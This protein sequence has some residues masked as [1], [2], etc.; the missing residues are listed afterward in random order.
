MKRKSAVVIMFTMLL[1]VVV[2]GAIVSNN[3][4]PKVSTINTNHLYKNIHSVNIDEDVFKNRM[5]QHELNAIDSNYEKKE[6]FITYKAIIEK[7]KDVAPVPKMIYDEYSE[8]D[9]KLLFGV[10]QAEVGDEHS[11]YEKCNVASVIFNRI[12]SSKFGNDISSVLTASQ[13]STIANGSYQRVN[14]SEDTI[15][16]CEYVYKFGDTTNGALYFESG[17]ANTHA[18]YAEYIF[19]DLAGHSFYK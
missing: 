7:Y 10:V 2:T 15:L 4:A 12:R 13:F 14:I 11:F 6:W 18:A 8:E 5:Y 3:N 1:F 9:L 16:A 19:T 17:G